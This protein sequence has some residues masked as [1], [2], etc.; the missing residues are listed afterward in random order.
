MM[1]A[2]VLFAISATILL[3]L[4]RAGAFGTVAYTVQQ[5]P[6]EVEARDRLE[7]S[8]A[9]LAVGVIIAILS[10]LFALL[11]SAY[12]PRYPE[13]YIQLPPLLW[14]NTGALLAGSI[15]LHY[16]SEAR[17]RDRLESRLKL[18]CLLGLLFLFG[19]LLVWRQLVTSGVVASSSMPAAFFYLITAMHALHFSGGLIALVWVMN[20]QTDF[21]HIRSFAK[22]CSAYWGFM[23]FAWLAI[24]AT[25]AG[26][27]ESFIDICRSLP[28][29]KG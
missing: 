8:P 20:L 23:F 9:A 4:R 10:I 1:L 14:A 16:A 24:F 21:D 5:S 28:L 11:L 29:L 25:I 19:Q 22:L 7:M 18:A 2:L 15:A 12:H 27:T 17:S 26:L 3:W 6:N 13:G